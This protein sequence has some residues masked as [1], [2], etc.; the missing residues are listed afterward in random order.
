MT[1]G[2]QGVFQPADRGV[3]EGTQDSNAI[4]AANHAGAQRRPAQ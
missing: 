3:I 1:H 4:G 2:N